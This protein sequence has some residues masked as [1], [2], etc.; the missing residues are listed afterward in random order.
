MSNHLSI[1]D[2]RILL[3]VVESHHVPPTERKAPDRGPSVV[4]GLKTTHNQIKYIDLIIINHYPN[5]DF[6]NMI[7]QIVLNYL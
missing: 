2:I 1:D 4:V 7:C 5:K 6:Q 3:F